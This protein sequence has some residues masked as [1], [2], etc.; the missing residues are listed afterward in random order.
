MSLLRRPWG[1][2]GSALAT[3]GLAG[4]LVV[5]LPADEAEAHG[6][7]THPATRT[8]ACY[9]DGRQ[10]GGGGNLNPTNPMCAAAW[11]ENQYGFWNWFGNLLPD[12]GGA[13]REVIPDGNLCGP[14]SD[15]SSFRAAPA[16]SWPTTTLQPGAGIEFQYNAWA[17]HPGTWSQYITTDNW[18]PDT[19]L[20]W[21]ELEPVPF[22]EITNPPM[23]QGGVEGAEYY[24]N[25]TLPNK[26]GQH[27]IFSIW[28]RSDSPEAFYNCSDVF[29]GSG[30][31]GN[32]GPGNGDDDDNGNGNGDDDNGDD[33]GDNGGVLGT[34]EFDLVGQ[35]E[36]GFQAEVAVT[37]SGDSAT[38]S[39]TAEW[40]FSDGQQIA[41]LWGGEYEQSGAEVT[42]T[43]APHNGSLAPG[44]SAT[45]GFIGSGSGSQPSDLQ[46]T[47]D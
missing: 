21:G 41:H 2:A 18:N 12:V 22:D 1:L 3:L 29:F 45:A 46:C 13:H 37:N 9:V 20:T 25:A 26:Q 16:S 28:E 33:N 40:T 35:W 7:L 30:G 42:V 39:W 10:G 32:G 44:E 36:D 15:F 24:W 4:T 8:Y 5:V 23:R 14:G 19:P 6:G 31:P 11:N 34:C 43:N 17:P 47:L 38:S 27:I